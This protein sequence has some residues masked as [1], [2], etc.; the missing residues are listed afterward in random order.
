MHLTKQREKK[1]DEDV[2][3]QKEIDEI[4]VLE[5]TKKA[6]ELAVKGLVTRPDVIIVDGN[7][8]FR[9]SRFVSY[10]K[11][12]DKSISIGAASIIAKVTRDRI[13]TELHKNFPYYLWSKNSGYGTLEHLQAI[14]KYGYS[15]HHRMSFKLKKLIHE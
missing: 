14:I 12:D 6:C 5:A 11:G 10:I 15:E 13:M 2:E 4:N 7:M 9:D 3:T 8:K 1:I